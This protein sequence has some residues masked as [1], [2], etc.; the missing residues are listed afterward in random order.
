M[1]KSQGIIRIENPEYRRRK[2]IRSM[3]LQS[4]LQAL[5]FCG[6]IVAYH[7]FAMPQLVN[8]AYID[9]R[10]D[11][12]KCAGLTASIESANV[13]FP[14]VCKGWKPQWTPNK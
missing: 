5:T 8:E 11:G 12:H 6:A 7:Y 9:G 3:I 4:I 2:F 14:E 10:L 1:M 13:P